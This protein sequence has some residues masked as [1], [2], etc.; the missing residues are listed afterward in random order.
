MDRI[1]NFITLIFISICTGFEH[2]GQNYMFPS[3]KMG[4]RQNA[5]ERN[6]TLLD[7]ELYAKKEKVKIEILRQLGMDRISNITAQ[8]DEIPMPMLQQAEEMEQVLMK[9][10]HKF[11]DQSNNFEKIAVFGT[12]GEDTLFLKMM[13]CLSYKK[14]C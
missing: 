11:D 3:Q 8:V 13:I 4:T 1:L 6:E 9:R 7:F 12:K 5:S 2:E 10:T 14:G